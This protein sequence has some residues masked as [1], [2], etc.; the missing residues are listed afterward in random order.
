M[1]NKTKSLLTTFALIAAL[2]VI[3]GSI[4]YGQAVDILEIVERVQQNT[5]NLQGGINSVYFKGRSKSYDYGKWNSMDMN[6]FPETEDYF[7]E[8]YWIKPDSL[9]IKVSAIRKTM[10]DHPAYGNSE[11]SKPDYLTTI[12]RSFPL[13]NP[14]QFNYDVSALSL[15]KGTRTDKYGNKVPIWPMFP[16]AAGADSLYNYEFISSVSVN[17]RKL[18][19]VYV[20]PKYDDIPAVA[21]TFQIDPELYEVVASDIIF[22]DAAKLMQ[23][24]NDNNMQSPAKHPLF[25]MSIEEEHLIKTEKML[26]FSVYWLPQ[27][28]EEDFTIKIMGG[29]IKFNRHVEFTDYVI[30]PD[31]SELDFVKNEK[32][33]YEQ[34]SE[35]QKILNKNLDKPYELTQEE[36]DSMVTT[37]N[38]GYA[39]EDLAVEIFDTELLG[40]NALKLSLDQKTGTYM[41]YARKWSDNVDYNRV[42]GLRIDVPLTFPDVFNRSSIVLKGGYG[43]KDE[44]FKGEMSG[45]VFLND[46]KSFFLE[47]NIYDKIT[48]NEDRNKFPNTKNTFSS[49]LYG[50]D[51][52]DYYYKTG[53]SFGIGFRPAENVG[54]KL[55]YISHDEKT[56]EVNTNFS[57]FRN[58]IDFRLNPEIMDGTFRGLRTTVIF[59]SANISADVSAEYTDEEVLN[60]NFSYTLY[61]TSLL[62]NRKINN[63][64]S[65]HFFISGG[66]TS[67]KLPPQKWFDFG[68]KS[69]AN[70]RGI[71]R[72]VGY[73]DFTGDRMAY[74]TMEYIMSAGDIYQFTYDKS[75]F[76]TVKKLVKF[77]FWAGFGWSELSAENLSYTNE[78][79][80]PV[81]TTEDTYSEF[82]IGISDRL[83]VFRM[84]FVRNSISENTILFSIN[85]FR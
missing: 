77:T 66:M 17:A 85:V 42:E 24:G 67:G 62:L 35:L 1:F 57:I 32:L 21:G 8:G 55:S 22:N 54:L 74:G 27:Q 82:G 13:P 78:I 3:T 30:N 6:F 18:I 70:Y 10:A 51:Y 33:V 39:N 26:F 47:G 83:N 14:F 5:Q 60:S 73:K 61:K 48:F 34:D 11:F 65:I 84:D 80:T 12:R 36:I 2:T 31:I 29:L 64:N 49:V 4:S 20:T 28:I 44:R 41:K 52:R 75:I 43:F 9:R 7:F 15:D 40:Q 59:R 58:N 63:K 37:L 69:L 19:K 72:G 56:A 53:V 16:F 23:Q 25:P 50:S 71:L 76:D 79:M 68:G 38:I 81:R 45:L 46:S